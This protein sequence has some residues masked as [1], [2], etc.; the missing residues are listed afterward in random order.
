[1]AQRS[2]VPP[3][4][5]DGYLSPL[6]WGEGHQLAYCQAGPVRKWADLFGLQE[7]TAGEKTHYDH[8]QVAEDEQ[9]SL[10]EHF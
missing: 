2:V 8:F 5:Q 6:A 3:A 10:F 4:V 7:V 1:M 9:E